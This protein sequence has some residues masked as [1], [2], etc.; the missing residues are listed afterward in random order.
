MQVNEQLKNKWSECL[1]LIENSCSK[2]DY[3]RWFSVLEPIAFEDGLLRLAVP[4]KTHI[5]YIERNFIPMLRPIIRSCFGIQTRLQYAIPDTATITSLPPQVKGNTS[6][7][8]AKN[9][10]VVPGLKKVNFDSQLHEELNFDTY[11]EGDCNRLARSAGKAIAVSP[12]TTA[13]NPLFVFG[14]SGLGK[15]HVVQAIGNEIMARNPDSRILYVSCDNFL[16]QFQRATFKKELNDFIYFYQTIDVL[17][18]DDIHEIAGKPATQNIFFN[19]FNHLKMLG[20]QIVLTADRPPVELEGIDERLITRFKWGLS[21]E[22]TSPDYKTRLTILRTKAES[23]G[24]KIEKDVLE[25]LAENIKANVRELE[26]ALTSLNAHSSFMGRAITLDL[27]RQVMR[28]IVSFTLKEVTVEAIMDLVCSVMGVSVE[29]V[30]SKRKT[31]ALASARQVAMYICKERTKATLKAIGMA[32]GG[33]THA[34]VMHACKTVPNLLDTDKILKGQVE[35]IER[36]LQ[37]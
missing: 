19:I 17:I 7:V 28:N 21:A 12:G 26:G 6:S 35:E 24:I 16:R 1:Q 18:V 30:V 14:N 8:T 27:T 31:R 11:I 23:M 9:V 10:Y 25:F 37:Y 32:F 33:R 13:F 36:K 3:S 5:D 22:I 20:K 29:E 15:T 34:T 2:E 4:N